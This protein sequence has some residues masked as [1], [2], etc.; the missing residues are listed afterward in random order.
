MLTQYTLKHQNN[1]EIA[2]ITKKKLNMN[3]HSP[4][5]KIFQRWSL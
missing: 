3:I 4:R 2:Y 1:T 5:V